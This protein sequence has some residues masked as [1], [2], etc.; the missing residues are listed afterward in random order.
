M[1]NSTIRFLTRHKAES[2]Q[3]IRVAH[4]NG[5]VQHIY[6]P[7]ELYMNPAL[8]DSVEV[9]DGIKL[10]SNSECIVVYERNSGQCKKG[11]TESSDKVVSTAVLA[12]DTDTTEATE[13]NSSINHPSETRTQK[14]EIRGP[15]L[16]LP[17]VNESIHTFNWSFDNTFQVLHTDPNRIWSVDLP[18]TTYDSAKF[19]A[20]LYIKYHMKSIEKCILSEDPIG[21]M[22]NGLKA[23][24]HLFGNIIS[25]EQ[26]QQQGQTNDVTK[27]LVD[28]DTYTSL[29]EAAEACGFCIDSVRVE[30]LCLSSV[31]QNQAS[32]DQKLSAT[33]RTEM[34]EKTQRRQLLE[35][36]I[37][38]CRKRIDQEAELKRI[39]VQTDAKLEEELHCLKEAELER[40]LYLRKMEVAADKEIE[41]IAD[42]NVMVF[43]KALKEEG[44]DMTKFLC[45]AGGLE[46]V[47]P[48]LAK[49]ASLK[50]ENDRT[51]IAWKLDK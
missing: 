51:K 28:L 27:G 24:A 11:V 36:E 15:T 29:Q 49:A 23:D 42:K 1:Y 3:Y 41:N 6:G 5:N 34:A 9:Y 48:V 31:L 30:S 20:L 45:T 22:H 40:R 14:R 18:I 2:H 50:A 37:E 21:K 26:L 19:S 8:H 10:K 46:I 17:S 25:S 43:L 33:L 38:D 4:R 13:S 47:S 44:V 35:L 12:S 32:S 39:Q 7:S 16:F